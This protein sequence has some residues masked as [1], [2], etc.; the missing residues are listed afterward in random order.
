MSSAQ[1]PSLLVQAAIDGD[2]AHVRHLVEVGSD[3]NQA[4]EHGWLPIHRAAALDRG[5]VVA[6]LL[7]AGSAIEARGTDG[8]TPLHLACVSGSSR[9]VAALV[10]GGADVNA[11]SKGGNTPLHLALVGVLSKQYAHV[12]RES[13]R[14]ARRT[15]ELLLAAGANPAVLDSQRRT[16][17]SIAREKGAKTLAYLLRKK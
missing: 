15:I 5:R 3:L 11:V 6:Y 1:P 17:A 13:V 16:P 9:A 8:W 7:A 14:H 10:K 12:H 4:D 2:L